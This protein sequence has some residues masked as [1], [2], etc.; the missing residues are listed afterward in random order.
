[1]WGFRVWRQGS[2]CRGGGGLAA[3]LVSGARALVC[4]LC[5]VEPVRPCL[6]LVASVYAYNRANGRMQF[7]SMYHGA[8][9]FGSYRIR[10]GP[11]FFSRSQVFLL[12]TWFLNCFVCLFSL[13]SVACASLVLVLWSKVM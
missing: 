11:E 1:M 6:L 10:R 9:E 5:I 7:E 2:F 8:Y 13:V 12:G 4:G 3:V